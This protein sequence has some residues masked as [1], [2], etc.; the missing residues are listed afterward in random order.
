M[1][2]GY[3]KITYHE[4]LKTP[5]DFYC[6]DQRFESSEVVVREHSHD[7]FEFF[8]VKSGKICH[9]INRRTEYLVPR[10]LQLIRPKDVHQVC[11][12]EHT[13]RI[14]FWNCNV[15][16]KLF[17]SCFHFLTENKVAIEDLGQNILLD[18]EQYH[19]LE[20]HFLRI[21]GKQTLSFGNSIKLEG[22]L[23]ILKVLFLFLRRNFTDEDAEPEWLK[24][25]MS[26]IC[27]PE[28]LKNGLPRFWELAG[29]SPE[30]VSRTMQHFYSISPR[31]YILKLRLQNA[32]SLLIYG[33]SPVKTV[34]FSCGFENLAYF[35]STFK[36]QF[37][38]TPLQY[39]KD[40]QKNYS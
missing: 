12:A 23:L 31:E 28:N 18:E 21:S 19:A 5:F 8:L 37:H 22:Q 13:P 14:A 40:F 35:H 11:C 17:L 16:P 32:A 4:F 10:T 1:M 24:N 26:A 9:K 27:I 29:V 33:D 38:A 25:A 7:F 30:H 39:R 15:Q 2:R 3:M 34:A 20:E 36:K 6:T